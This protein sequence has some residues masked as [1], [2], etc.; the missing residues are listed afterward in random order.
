[1]PGYAPIGSGPLGASAG[2]GAYAPTN[3]SLTLTGFAPTYVFKDGTI[4][5][6]GAASLALTG[7]APSLAGQSDVPV[8]AGAFVITE[9]APAIRNDF[10]FSPDAQHVAVTGFAPTLDAWIEQADT[11][12]T[13]TP[14]S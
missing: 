9:L 14:V 7:Y 3:A 2:G 11:S 6:P 10:T 4:V 13:W 12:E 8:G 1:M 5:Y